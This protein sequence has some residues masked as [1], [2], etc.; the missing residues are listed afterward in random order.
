M[1]K[2]ATLFAIVATQTMAFEK[3][4]DNLTVTV[5]PNAVEVY[6]GSQHLFSQDCRDFS[7]KI[8]TT[9]VE[10]PSLQIE[11]G[12]IKVNRDVSEVTT[13]NI[14]SFKPFYWTDHNYVSFIVSQASVSG[15]QNSTTQYLINT[16]NGSVQ[17]DK[18][19][20]DFYKNG[21]PFNSKLKEK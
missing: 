1:K 19:E 11:D 18:N 20:S 10:N 4:I 8:F 17:V 12:W 9:T 5:K 15:T 21:L 13:D 6:R 2:L 3:E 16:L 14:N 7:C